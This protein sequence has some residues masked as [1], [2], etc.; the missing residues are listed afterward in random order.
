MTKRVHVV[1]VLCESCGDLL[2]FMLQLL[3]RKLVSDC[4]L[5]LEQPYFLLPAE[6]LVL[7]P[8]KLVQN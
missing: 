3:A 8:L 2:D 4:S 5:G 7:N 1:G 6:P